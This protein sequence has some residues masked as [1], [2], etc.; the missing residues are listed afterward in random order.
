M[1]RSIRQELLVSALFI[2]TV[3]LVSTGLL[4]VA[5]LVRTGNDRTDEYLRNRN[6]ALVYFIEG[7][8]SEI[9]N[10]IRFLATDP[11]VR[12]AEAVAP[13]DHAV[14][15][16]RYRAVSRI[17]ENILFLYSGYEHGLMLINDWDP[18]DDFDHRTRPWY[19]SAMTNPGEIVT[20]EPFREAATGDWIISPAV[21]LHNDNGAVTGV[22]AIDSSV[23]RI[24]SLLA[25]EEEYAGGASFM[26]DSRGRMI[27]HHDEALLGSYHPLAEQDLSLPWGFVS[28]RDDQGA[29]QGFFSRLPELDWIVVSEVQTR[30][31]IAH[32]MRTILLN[33]A[34]LAT[35]LVA[36][37]FLQSVVLGRRFVSPILEITPALEHVAR[38][39]FT[40]TITVQG[41]TEL[42]SLAESARTVVK[43]FV[44]TIGYARD[45]VQRLTDQARTLSAASENSAAIT[46]QQSA[47][48]TEI[49]STTEEAGN[50]A[51]R[52][53]QNM[54]GIARSTTE[55]VNIVQDGVEQIRTVRHQMD[56]ISRAND[57]TIT[58]I[59]DLSETVESIWE[60]L[61]IINGITEQTRIIAFS[62][63]LEAS[64]ADGGS[65]EN[66]HIVSAEIRRLADSTVESTALIRKRL[67]EVRSSSGSLKELSRMGTRII[68]HGRSLSRDVETVFEGIL[69]RSRD[70][71]GAVNDSVSVVTQ[72]NVSFEQIIKALH[73]IAEGVHSAAESTTETTRVAEEL[74]RVGDEL[75]QHLM[76]FR[77][78]P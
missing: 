34:I 60:I 14:V 20:G 46:N 69:E 78:S 35:I 55:T 37:A 42:S 7:Y 11:A 47:A 64:A 68:E 73:Q 52:V 4:L 71:A 45:S 54:T 29:K 2:T 59:E 32:R 38:G 5:V 57:K 27:V 15:L 19:Q 21:T 30:Y 48:V 6:T 43:K 18:P 17:N 72:Q 53:E 22:L 25:R 50:L 75:E 44:D 33:V 74:R 3:T 61:Q 76:Q 26:L 24:A 51:Q 62:A 70:S 41:N 36:L 56:E 65:G 28:Y 9:F 49:V 1:K 13:A 23:N 31:I 66:F 58:G 16:D 8:F 77:V 40:G 12:D 67:E 10:T 63:E 39:D